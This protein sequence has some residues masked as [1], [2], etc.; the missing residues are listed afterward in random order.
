MTKILFIAFIILMINLPFGFWRAGVKKLSVRWFLAVHIPVVLI[1]LIR[2]TSQLGWH[3]ITFPFII[4][5]YFAGQFLGGKFLLLY[6][7]KQ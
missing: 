5:G 6:K 4:G 1:I 2:F 3:L 7:G